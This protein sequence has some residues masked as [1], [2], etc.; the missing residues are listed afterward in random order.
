L[1]RNGRAC[2]YD[3]S[4]RTA[5]LLTSPIS[6]YHPSPYITHLLIPPISTLHTARSHFDRFPRPPHHPSSLNNRQ[7]RYPINRRIHSLPRRF[8]GTRP[9]RIT[10]TKPLIPRCNR[11][12]RISQIR[13]TLHLA[14]NPLPDPQIKSLIIG[15]RL[16]AEGP[17]ARD[18]GFGG[19][20]EPIC[21]LGGCRCC[22]IP[23]GAVAD[24]AVAVLGVG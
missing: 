23:F 9:P 11:Q 22:G 8:R 7:V 5:R 6:S 13:L 10:D 3:M 24:H 16:D 17:R 2:P 18:G 20:G 1:F 21:W 19:A 12:I 14:T 15:I 4:L